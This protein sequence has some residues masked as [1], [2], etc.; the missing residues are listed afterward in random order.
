MGG[1]GAGDMLQCRRV[2]TFRRSKTMIAATV[3]WCGLHTLNNCLLL[4][5]GLLPVMVQHH[6]N[7][8]KTICQKKNLVWCDEIYKLNIQNGVLNSTNRILWLWH[9]TC[10]KNKIV[11]NLFTRWH[12]AVSYICANKTKFNCFENV[13]WSHVVCV[14]HLFSI[15]FFQ[16]ANYS[17]IACFLGFRTRKF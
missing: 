8:L 10:T 17:K 15:L 7:N 3:L 9:A 4:L 14:S 6:L 13:F 11:D 5:I 2:P 12:I 16:P 1:G